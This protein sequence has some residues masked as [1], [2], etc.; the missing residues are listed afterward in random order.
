MPGQ[1]TIFARVY[2]ETFEN[3]YAIFVIMLHIAR[4]VRAA[5][6]LAM[7]GYWDAMVYSV[8][9]R[10]KVNQVVAVGLVALFV[11]ILGSCVLLPAG[12][13]LAS[14]FSGVPLWR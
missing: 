12:V 4:P 6:A 3:W 7:R 11:D 13:A 9:E 5:L 8:K 1:W 14:L 2:E 10:L